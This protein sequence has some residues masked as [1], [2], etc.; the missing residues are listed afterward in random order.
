MNAPLSCS[1]PSEAVV[2][3]N[4]I[5]THDF[6][7]TR[8]L[9]I[10]KREKCQPHYLENECKIILTHASVILVCKNLYQIIQWAPLFQD[11]TLSNG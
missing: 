7:L 2:G 1:I 3:G 4:E 5:L 8:M 11:L 10:G 9:E 6:Y